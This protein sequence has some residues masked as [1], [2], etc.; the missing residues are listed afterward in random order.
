MYPTSR[1][2][3]A[4]ALTSLCAAFV[5]CGSKSNDNKNQPVTPQEVAEG[6][7]ILSA[8]GNQVALYKAGPIEAKILA[9]ETPSVM[10][11]DEVFAMYPSISSRYSFLGTINKAI[12]TDANTLDLYSNDVLVL[13]LA[14]DTAA[15][16]W[17]IANSSNGLTVDKI[18]F[19]ESFADQSG[20]HPDSLHFVLSECKAVEQQAPA[21]APA[22]EEAKPEEKPV[23]QQQAQAQQAQLPEAQA[24][25][26]LMGAPE[27]KPE[28]QVKPEAKPEVQQA[29]EEAKPE[30][31]PVEE[32]K[33]EQKC[34]SVEALLWLEEQKVEVQQQQQQA[35]QEEVKPEAKPEAQQAPVQEA[36]PEAQQAPVQEAKPEQKPEAQQAP[37]Q[38]QQAPTAQGAE[39]QTIVET[40][41]VAQHRGHYNGYDYSD[42]V[43]THEKPG[44]ETPYTMFPNSGLPPF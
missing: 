38:A 4:L 18:A 10:S 26:K 3:K 31:K 22:Q 36:K 33:P 17:S 42:E 8:S 44:Y 9:S 16:T 23:E 25:A 6:Q 15:D 32:V 21:Q 11:V 39:G 14:H 37:T 19:M 41:T 20:S 29:Q 35:Q 12:K 30:E 27:A 7:G 34:A 5:A 13:T 24:Q 43:V 1:V 2:L 28:E 40:P